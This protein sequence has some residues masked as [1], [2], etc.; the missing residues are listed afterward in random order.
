MHRADNRLSRFVPAERLGRMFVM[1]LN[2]AT[3]SRSQVSHVAEGITIKRPSFQLRKPARHG[4][5]S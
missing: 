2:E 5:Q 1:S 4:V 3:N